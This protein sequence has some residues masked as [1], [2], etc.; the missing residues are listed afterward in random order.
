MEV[1]DL[2]KNVKKGICLS[3]WR[4]WFLFCIS[5]DI[6]FLWCFDEPL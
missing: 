6:T 4:N 2:V 3:L 5:L 1:L